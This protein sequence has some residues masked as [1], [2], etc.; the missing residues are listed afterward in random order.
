MKYVL[1]FVFCFIK[2][3]CAT[4][5]KLL[6]IY[7]CALGPNAKSRQPNCNFIMEPNFLGTSH[8]YFK[9]AC[10]YACVDTSW[11]KT[12]TPTKG[13]WLNFESKEN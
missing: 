2:T 8:L 9:L 12:K 4:L 7:L 1:E 10:T 3:T 11:K 5:L 13:F 6:I